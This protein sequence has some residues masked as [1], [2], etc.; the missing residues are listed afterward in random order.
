MKP[1]RIRIE[2]LGSAV[3]AALDE[4]GEGRRLNR[5]VEVHIRGDVSE[6]VRFTNKLEEIR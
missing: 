6:A 3:T 5:R 1:D 4:T 2:A